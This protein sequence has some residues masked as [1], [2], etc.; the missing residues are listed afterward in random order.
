MLT[1]GFAMQHPILC[2]GSSAPILGT[3]VSTAP[4]T[5]V[6]RVLRALWQLFLAFCLPGTGGMAHPDKGHAA[7]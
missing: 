4:I 6:V 7:N 2:W 1:H 5:W 3:T